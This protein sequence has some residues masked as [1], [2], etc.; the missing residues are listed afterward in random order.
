[1]TRA[2]ATA[3]AIFVVVAFALHRATRTWSFAEPTLLLAMGS[4]FL[5]ASRLVGAELAPVAEDATP[6]VE[7]A[8]EVRSA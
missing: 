8:R 1:M 5:V 2:I 3:A 7:V 4:M 6:I